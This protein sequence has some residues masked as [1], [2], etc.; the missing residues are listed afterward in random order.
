MSKIGIAIQEISGGAVIK[1]KFNEQLDF[2]RAIRDW[3]QINQY[4]NVAQGERLRFLTFL[5]SGCLIGQ[6]QPVADRGGDCIVLWIFL[7]DLVDI[8][9][10]QIVDLLDETSQAMQQPQQRS[11][12]LA[13]IA[14]REYPQK[15]FPVHTMKSTPQGSIAWRAYKDDEHLARIIGPCRCQAEYAKYSMV[16]LIDEREQTRPNPAAASRMV[17]L[18]QNPLRE[19]CLV[20]SPSGSPEGFMVTIEGSPITWQKKQAYVGDELTLVW[21]KPG[22]KSMSKTIRLKEGDNQLP[23]LPVEQCVR[24]LQQ[25]E[26]KV[27]DQS[28]RQLSDFTVLID[29]KPVQ[30]PRVFRWNELQAPLSISVKAPGFKT[31]DAKLTDLKKNV[32]NYM[33][34][35]EPKPIRVDIDSYV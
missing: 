31:S 2:V 28:G 30:F 10:E 22:W 1:E 4:F 21:H 8:Q 15:E 12:L 27:C 23:T 19:S 35:L 20:I 6:H 25:N 24:N 18:S 9:G 26:F 17:N 7:P 33:F 13:Q 29:N 34:S 3:R 32:G 14:E 5:D 16:V 11:Q